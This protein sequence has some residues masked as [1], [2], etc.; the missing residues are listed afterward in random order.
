MSQPPVSRLPFKIAPI[1]AAEDVGNERCGVLTFPRYNDLTVN[2][3]AWIT[4][5][6]VDTNSFNCTSRLAL[7]I[8]KL[9]GV[10]PL[11]AHGFVAKVLAMAMGSTLKLS[12]E[13]EDWTVKYVKE[14]EATAMKVVDMALSQQNLLVTAVI[15]HRLPDTTNWTL[16]DTGRL[17]S[18]LVECI[19]TFAQKE[20]N[21]GQL[22]TLEEVN[23]EIE[24]SLG[25]LQTEV[26]KTPRK[27]TGRKSSTGFNSSTPVAETSLTTVSDSS[28]ALTPSNA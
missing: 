16:E 20:R 23:A 8:A 25:K 9:E 2:E 7:K 12:E 21:H 14:L 13:E 11:V 5:Q 28:P 1:I 17:P 15:R 18:E 6:A 26:T 19:Y 27:R 4:S 3:S 10:K 22:T 24:E